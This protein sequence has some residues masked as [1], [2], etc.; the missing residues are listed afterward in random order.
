[1]LTHMQQLSK[2]FFVYLLANK[3]SGTIYIGVTADLARRV[4]EHKQ[5]LVGGF[6]TKYCIE[7]LVYFEKHSTAFSAI[8]R[9]KNLK[10]WLRQWKIVLI[11]KE[12]PEWKDLTP[13]LNSLD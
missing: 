11:E 10:K 8:Q 12:N 13:M 9:E 7:T 5:H 4:F 1:M 6:T 3:K 2:Q